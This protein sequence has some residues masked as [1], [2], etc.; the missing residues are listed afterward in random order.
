MRQTGDRAGG[1][2]TVMELI[3][4]DYQSVTSPASRRS[5]GK[6]Q[7]VQNPI[8]PHTLLDKKEVKLNMIS[9]AL[10]VCENLK[11]IGGVISI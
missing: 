11:S 4:C 1:M 10:E 6:C 9:C 7:I 2:M 8:A 3:H 5:E